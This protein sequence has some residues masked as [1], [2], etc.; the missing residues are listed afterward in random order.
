MKKYEKVK[1]LSKFFGVGRIRINRVLREQ[2]INIDNF[3][4]LLDKGNVNRD[5]FYDLFN[6]ESLADIYWNKMFDDA[7]V[8][9]NLNLTKD[10]DKILGVD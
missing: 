3:Y 6:D 1:V 5:E 10:L 8:E 4:D 9:E 7:D 2:Q